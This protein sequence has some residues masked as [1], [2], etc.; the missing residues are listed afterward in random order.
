[1]CE[2]PPHTRGRYC[3]LPVLEGSALSGS[4]SGHAPFDSE[5]HGQ[6]EGNCLCSAS[7][8]ISLETETNK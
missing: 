1:M 4:G 7:N 6:P 3:E 8:E 5:Y 2:C